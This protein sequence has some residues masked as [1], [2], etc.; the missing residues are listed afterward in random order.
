MFID[1]NPI[2][3]RQ[4]R[5]ENGKRRNLGWEREGNREKGGKKRR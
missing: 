5:G 1:L 3:M 4:G 2:L